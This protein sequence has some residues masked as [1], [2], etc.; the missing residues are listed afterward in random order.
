MIVGYLLLPLIPWFRHGN[1]PWI[2]IGLFTVL[3]IQGTVTQSNWELKHH[4]SSVALAFLIVGVPAL[5][6]VGMRMQVNRIALAA[7]ALAAVIAA[8][9]VGRVREDFYLDH[10]YVTAVRPP[11]S[12]GFRA[13]PEWQPLQDWGRNAKDERIG[14]VGRASAFGQYFFYGNDLSNHVQYVGTELRRGTFRPIDNCTRWRRTVNE[15]DYDYIV[16]TPKIGAIEINAPPEALWT[17]SDDNVS[18]VISTGPAAVYKIN[19]P[20]DPSTC[21]ELG[22]AAHT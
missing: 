7:F 6:V 10:R 12:G 3:L 2:L 14:V 8:V 16:T 5:L 21:S 19:G 22:I 18:T 4:L 15:G 9:V 11:L 13:T 17:K 1:R 20:L